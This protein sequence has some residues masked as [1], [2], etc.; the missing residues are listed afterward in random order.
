MKSL[1]IAIMSLSFGCLDAPD[2]SITP[3]P[4]VERQAPVDD[5]NSMALPTS[6]ATDTLPPGWCN[7]NSDCPTDYQCVV[8]DCRK[9]GT[10]PPCEIHYCVYNP[11]GDG[12]W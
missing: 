6:T 2:T 5:D 4:D 3:T 12:G 11:Y 1:M 9:T 7:S 8:R 10:S